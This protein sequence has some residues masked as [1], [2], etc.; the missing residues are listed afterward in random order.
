MTV[1][2]QKANITKRVA[3]ALLDFI[4]LT[5]IVTGAATALTAA[6]GYDTYVNTADARQKYFEEQY[7][8]RFEIT[9]EEYL[10]FSEE[11]Q[12]LYND[13]YK[14]FRQDKE[15]LYAYNMMLNLVTITIS[16]S[17][18]LGVAIVE[19][20]IP[21][22]LKNGQ[23]VG[24]KVF[25]IGL[26]RVDG[27]QLTTLQLFTRTILGKFTVEL[28]I[29]AYIIIMLYFSIADIISLAILIIILI[30]QVVC[31]IVTR[32]NSAFHDLLSG[33][34]AIDIASQQIFR[35]KEELLEYTKKAHAEQA[36]R[37]VY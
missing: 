2:L 22:I 14:A 20:I 5:I 12:Q 30:V 36:N 10:A 8:V 4:L 13:A 19:F 15:F 29:P 25:G 11:K 9:E 21:L 3:A 34:V 31:P 37:S 28:M 32:T 23:T 17:L 6:F 1:D 26:V 16:L 24:K 18:L 27:V 7:G 33:T 35:S